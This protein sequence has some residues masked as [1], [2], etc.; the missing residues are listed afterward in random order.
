MRSGQIRGNK[1][2]ISTR[3][4]CTQALEDSGES[5][6]QSRNTLGRKSCIIANGPFPPAGPLEKPTPTCAL[7]VPG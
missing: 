3:Q 6:S 5:W 2:Q 1:L 4:S 7:S